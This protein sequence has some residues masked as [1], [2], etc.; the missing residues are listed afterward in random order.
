[1]HNAIVSS[2]ESTH[3]DHGL[4]F[5]YFHLSTQFYVLHFGYAFIVLKNPD[6]WRKALDFLL[7]LLIVILQYY[8]R[9]SAVGLKDQRFL[10]FVQGPELINLD[11]FFLSSGDDFRTVL[12]L[13]KIVKKANFLPSC[14]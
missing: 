5:A 9:R 3:A 12:D 10:Y 6:I 4:L 14:N 7:P 8:L 1:M 13:M 11:V 2:V